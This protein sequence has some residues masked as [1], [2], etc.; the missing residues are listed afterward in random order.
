[1]AASASPSLACGIVVL[2]RR[3]ELLLCHATG[4]ARWDIPKGGGD[5]GESDAEVAIRETAEE[6][7]LMFE[8]DRLLDLGRFAY[9][10]GK[11]LH[12]YAALIDRIDPATCVC[13][14]TFV[15]R[16]GRS[17]PEM[18]RFEWV[19]FDRV[20]EHAGKSLAALL[21]ALSLPRVLA[22]LGGA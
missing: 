10:R 17:V 15:D 20:G 12:L 8:P 9:R 18:D 5:A 21:C 22:R 16:F 6:T 2:N 11:D 4:T 14:S 3:A 19:P 13:R 1:M 7:G